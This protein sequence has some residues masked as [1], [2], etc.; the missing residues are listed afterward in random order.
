MFD[1]LIILALGLFLIYDLRA[2]LLEKQNERD[3]R[4][5]TKSDGDA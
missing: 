3:E 5:R 1:Y 2:F 4:E